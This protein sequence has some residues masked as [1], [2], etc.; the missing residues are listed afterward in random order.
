MID[1]LK[2]NDPIMNE[3]NLLNNY[4]DKS[5][6]IMGSSVLQVEFISRL[7]YDITVGKYHYLLLITH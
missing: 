7:Y 1:E 4:G 3:Y 5:K 6:S 2:Q